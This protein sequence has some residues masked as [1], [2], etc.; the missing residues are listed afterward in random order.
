MV[1]EVNN[2]H[3]TQKSHYSNLMYCNEPILKAERRS[4]LRSDLTWFR[5]IH[6]WIENFVDYSI[7]G[8]RKLLLQDLEKQNPNFSY[9][10]YVEAYHKYVRPKEDV[11]KIFTAF[12][13]V[14]FE[15]LNRIDS[16]NAS[17]DDQYVL[18]K[19]NLNLI[20][21][22][23]YVY[24]FDFAYEEFMSV[25]S[26]QKNLQEQR[27]AFTIKTKDDALFDGTHIDVLVYNEENKLVSI[28][29]CESVYHKRSAYYLDP[30]L[31]YENEI[32]RIQTRLGTPIYT[33]FIDVNGMVVRFEKTI[34]K[35]NKTE[36]TQ[37]VSNQRHENL[38]TN[39]EQSKLKLQ[40]V[41][42]NSNSNQS[43]P[44]FL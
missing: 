32:K 21:N 24:L 30:M 39:V 28:I 17:Q 18:N 29:Y 16:P 11:E 33:F 3:P 8:N 9:N 7:I 19:T 22:L 5:F 44:T 1:T 10:E 31:K 12:A 36:N 27:P 2:L 43:T 20:V 6:L 15:Y 13:G 26:F 4:G 40:Y 42:P 14:V 37:Q 25:R 34:K 41:N 35:E 23:A 38:N